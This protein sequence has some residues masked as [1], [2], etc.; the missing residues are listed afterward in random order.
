MLPNTRDSSSSITPFQ[1]PYGTLLYSITSARGTGPWG[2]VPMRC[3]SIPNEASFHTTGS[4]LWYLFHE[5]PLPQGI[6][7]LHTRH[8]SMERSPYKVSFLVPAAE[9][10]I[11]LG[12]RIKPGSTFI[13]HHSLISVLMSRSYIT[14]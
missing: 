12:Y 2:V 7:Q 11:G 5:T 6:N 8:S 3:S 10:E 9:W 1:N 4:K 14:A 13:L